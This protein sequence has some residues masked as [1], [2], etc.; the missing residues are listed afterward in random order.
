MEKELNS[1]LKF[2][3][4]QPVQNYAARLV[5]RTRKKGTLAS[6]TFQVTLRD[7]VSH[8]QRTEWNSTTVSK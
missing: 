8:T 1:I 5:T 3:C 7:P 6:Y 4:Y 2:C